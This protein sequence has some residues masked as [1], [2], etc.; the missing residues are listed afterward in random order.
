MKVGDLVKIA[1]LWPN[2]SEDNVGEMAVITYKISDEEVEVQILHKNGGSEP[3]I[4]RNEHL[5]MLNEN[6]S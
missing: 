4:Y 2:W 3:W 6:V 1:E 5:E